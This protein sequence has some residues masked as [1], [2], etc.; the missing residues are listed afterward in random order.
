MAARI[1]ASIFS[2]EAPFQSLSPAQE[3]LKREIYEKMRPG[4]RKFVDRLGYDNWDPFQEPNHPLDMRVDACMRTTEQLL[5]EFL[6][7]L[8]HEDVSAEYRRGALDCAIAV[9]TKDEKYR[10]V[11]DFCLWYYDL[12]KNEGFMP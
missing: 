10:G 4:R 1:P 5:Q 2:E 8:G 3:K 9:V 7:S 12:L 6:A 11:F